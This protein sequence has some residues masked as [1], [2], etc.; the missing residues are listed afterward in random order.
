MRLKDVVKNSAAIKNGEWVA[1]GEEF[2]E[3]EVL[4]RGLTDPFLDAQAAKQRQAAKGFG[5]E[6]ARLPVATR[7]KI[8]IDCLNKH[9]LLDVRG[10]TDDEGRALTIDEFKDLLYDPAYEELVTACFLAAKQVGERRDDDLGDAAGNF[11]PA[12]AGT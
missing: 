12:S 2:G 3:V 9:V 1:L 4:T 8:N 5:G 7:R 6:V 10:L 11:A